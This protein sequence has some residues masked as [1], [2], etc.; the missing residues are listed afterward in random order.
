MLIF[1]GSFFFLYI[2]VFFCVIVPLN[3]VILFLD[4]VDLP[5]FGVTVGDGCYHLH[6]LYPLTFDICI[7]MFLSVRMADNS[8]EDGIISRAGRPIGCT[9]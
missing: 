6:G 4:L 8:H 7:P 9:W 2:Y 1:S 5:M 3:I